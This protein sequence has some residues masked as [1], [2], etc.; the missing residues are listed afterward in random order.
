MRL[1]DRVAIITGVAAASAG[2]LP[3]LMQKRAPSLVWRDGHKA[4]WN[5]LPARQKAW[6]PKPALFHHLFHQSQVERMEQVVEQRFGT[7]DVLVDN[8]AIVGPIGPLQDNDVSAWIQTIHLN[9]IG[10]YLCCRAV[11]S[12]M[13]RQNR[14]KIIILSGGG[15][16]F[17]W[18]QM[19]AYCA[20]KVALV[21][22]AE[23]LALEL[24]GKNIQVNAMRPGTIATDGLREVIDG[25]RESGDT[26]MVAV[27][28]RLLPGDDGDISGRLINAEDDFLDLPNRSK[29]ITDSAAYMLRRVE[30]S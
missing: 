1:E 26:K 10:T 8:A 9:L 28:Q 20:T 18:R 4:I 5:R 15:G 21:R 22:L 2:P 7:I 23:T 11:L 14:G 27:G 29:E 25:W 30:L 24:V 3:W 16:A 17:A 6:A 12:L 19:S 13:L